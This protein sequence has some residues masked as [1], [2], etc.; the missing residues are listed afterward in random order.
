MVINMGVKINIYY[1]DLTDE[2]SIVLDEDIESINGEVYLKVPD[3][4]HELWFMLNELLKINSK[5]MFDL[6]LTAHIKQCVHRDN[7]S[8]TRITHALGLGE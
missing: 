2:E 6:V 4:P 8:L 1:M 3:E 7:L 5:R